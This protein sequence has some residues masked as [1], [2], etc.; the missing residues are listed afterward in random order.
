MIKD[1]FFISISNVDVE[2]LFFM[3][4]DVMIYRRNRLQ[5]STIEKIMIFKK[6]YEIVHEISNVVVDASMSSL[7]DMILDDETSI[8][9]MKFIE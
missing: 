8:E 3:I 9:L 2:K 4:R 6:T 1:V 5:D 7:K